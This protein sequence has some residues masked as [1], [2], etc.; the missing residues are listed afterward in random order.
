MKLFVQDK[1]NFT[2]LVDYLLP[3]ALEVDGCELLFPDSLFFDESGK[4]LFVAKTDNKDGKMMKVD[5]P[6]KLGLSD[7]R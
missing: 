2:K 3:P 1:I 6:N 7:V 4:A 5:Q